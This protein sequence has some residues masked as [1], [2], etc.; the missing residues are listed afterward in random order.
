MLGEAV[1]GPWMM[2]EFKS[3]EKYEGT[4]IRPDIF[5]PKLISDLLCLADNGR[6]VFKRFPL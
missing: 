4:Q 3:D 1:N 2:D 6:C 5:F